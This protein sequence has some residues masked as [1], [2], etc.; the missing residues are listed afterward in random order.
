MRKGRTFL[1]DVLPFS[2][3]SVNRSLNASCNTTNSP[4]NVPKA[5]RPLAEGMGYC[6]SVRYSIRC[7]RFLAYC[8]SSI[9]PVHWGKYYK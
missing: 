6:L 4:G 9:A 5:C 7:V 8:K 3:Q 2:Y 1:Q